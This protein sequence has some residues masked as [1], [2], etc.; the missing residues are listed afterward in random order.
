MSAPDK[1]GRPVAA[2]T[3]RKQIMRT[4]GPIAPE[5]I[6]SIGELARAG[7]PQA[8]VAAATLLGAALAHE[9]KG[10]KVNEAPP[11]MA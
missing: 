5:L 11:V 6:R 8:Q 1:G 9:G 2:S 3:V 10:A 4:L 7:D